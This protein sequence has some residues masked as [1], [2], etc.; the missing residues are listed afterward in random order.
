MQKTIVDT[1]PGILK[2]LA[3]KNPVFVFIN[4]LPALAFF[5]YNIL[6]AGVPKASDAGY[7]LFGI[8]YW[9]FFE[10][11]V[12]RWLYHT[13]FTSQRVR[14]LFETFHLHHHRDLSDKRV[15]NAG[16]LMQYPLLATLLAPVYWFTGYDL[17]IISVTGLGL[18]GYYLF[19]ECV[20]YGIHYKKFAGGYMQYIQ[21]YHMYHHE[22]AWL[23]NFGNTS[24]VWDMVFNTM[25][26]KYKNYELTEE[27]SGSLIVNR[28]SK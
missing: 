16:P 27:Q 12:H 15:L 10:Y 28:I 26:E 17:R 14:W 2:I 20:H 25:D 13:R 5:L 21:K 6:A 4:I 7:F 3:S 8:F 19:Y 24:H 1:H 23:K 18:A 9:S 11:A 22:K